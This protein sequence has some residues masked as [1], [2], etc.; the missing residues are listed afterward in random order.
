M[1]RTLWILSDSS[2]W[3]SVVTARSRAAGVGIW[4]VGA[5][6]SSTY[7]SSFLRMKVRGVRSAGVCGP[8]AAIEPPRPAY[9]ASR[10]GRLGP[11]ALNLTPLGATHDRR[12][13]GLRHG[14]CGGEA[15]RKGLRWS[16]SGRTSAPRRVWPGLAGEAGFRSA[17]SVHSV[18]WHGWS[19]AL[20]RLFEK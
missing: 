10:S 1:S 20:P 12:Q 14:A 6:M 13:H 2:A 8:D 17:G 16:F 4:R 18:S 11:P 3:V 15:D 9:G 7:Y 5:P 19:I